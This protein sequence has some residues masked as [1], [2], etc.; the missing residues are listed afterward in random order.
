MAQQHGSIAPPSAAYGIAVLA[1]LEGPSGNSELIEG[2]RPLPLYSVL[3]EVWYVRAGM[4]LHGNGANCSSI[5]AY[6]RF[7]ESHRSGYG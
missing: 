4:E 3:V 5:S 1:Q 6:Y 2:P 7:V